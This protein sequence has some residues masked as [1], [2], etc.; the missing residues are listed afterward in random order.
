MYIGT[1][2]IVAVLGLFVVLNSYANSLDQQVQ[3]LNASI[4]NLKRDKKIEGDLIALS[5]QTALISQFLGNHLFWTKALSRIA[6]ATVPQVQMQTLAAS[7]ARKEVLIKA[8]APNYT[9]IARQM[10]SLVSDDGL[11]NVELSNAKTSNTG[12]VEF[13]VQLKIDET[14]Y[15]KK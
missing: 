14:K 13:T 8:V 1:A 11:V 3:D 9:A 2:V 15:L 12:G 7:A 5:K 4:A 10:A 6:N